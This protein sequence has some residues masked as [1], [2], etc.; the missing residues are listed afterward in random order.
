MN[1]LYWLA[2][3][4]LIS[5]LIWTRMDGDWKELTVITTTL[6]MVVLFIWGLNGLIGGV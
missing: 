1:I 3:I 4:P 6:T 2:M 5:F